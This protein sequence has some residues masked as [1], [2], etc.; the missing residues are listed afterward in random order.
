VRTGI[1]GAPRR[2]VC[3]PTGERDR[4]RARGRLHHFHIAEGE[5]AQAHAQRLHDRLL[6]REAGGQPLRRI[7]LPAPVR[8]LGRRK[9]PVGDTGPLLKGPPKTFDFHCV[10]PYTNQ[11]R[12]KLRRPRAPPESAPF[13]DLGVVTRP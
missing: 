10:N 11:G 9:Q 13:G 5:R 2:E 4:R 8:Q 3:S 1:I 12:P 7:P 6:G